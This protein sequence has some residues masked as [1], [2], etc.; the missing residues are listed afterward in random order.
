[1]AKV[2]ERSLYQTDY[3][4]WTKQQAAELRKL[5]ATRAHA[6]LDLENLAEEVESL[7]RSDLNTV[8]R[9][10][11]RIIEHLLKLEYSPSMPPRADWRY[12][13]AQA[14]DEVEDHITASMYPDVAADLG[15]LFGRARRDAALSLVKHGERHAAK[16][17]PADC[18][19]TFDQIVSQDWYPANRHGIL[20]AAA[21]A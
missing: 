1:V 9:Q 18:P 16:G 8:R 6:T 7:G 3:Y 11:R 20:D 10:V 21:D 4:A 13:V 12:S 2:L 5:A 17:L 19:Y 14:R 15:K